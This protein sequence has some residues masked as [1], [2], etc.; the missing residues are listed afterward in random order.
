MLGLSALPNTCGKRRSQQFTGSMVESPDK[1]MQAPD[2][3]VQTAKHLRHEQQEIHL[4]CTWRCLQAYLLTTI[5]S[6][7]WPGRHQPYQ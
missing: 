4:T 5:S 6:A 2:V 7:H 1:S 3:V